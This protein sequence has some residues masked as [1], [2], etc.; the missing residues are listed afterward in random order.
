M[1]ETEMHS[2]TSTQWCSV[3]DSLYP[4]GHLHLNHHTNASQTCQKCIFCTNL[5]LYPPSVL[6]HSPPL[7]RLSI[8]PHSSKSLPSP[9][10]PGP[11]G[12]SSRKDELPKKIRK[13]QHKSQLNEGFFPSNW[14]TF[15]KDPYSSSTQLLYL[16][17]DSATGLTGYLAKGLVTRAIS[18]AIS[19]QICC[20]SQMRFGVS[21]IWCRTR[22]STVYT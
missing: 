8:M 14:L 7:Q 12:H 16:V 18:C 6:T 2:S 5:N 4:R 19:C 3:E 17:F 22:N 21:A 1:P 20:K 13:V 9:S 11:S 15:G 10:R